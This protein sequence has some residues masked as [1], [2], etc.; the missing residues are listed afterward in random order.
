[1]M[2]AFIGFL[3]TYPLKRTVFVRR[4]FQSWS[5]STRLQSK[6]RRSPAVSLHSALATPKLRVSN[7]PK[8]WYVRQ[9][10]EKL[11]C[12]CDYI[13]SSQTTKHTFSQNNC[14]FFLKILWSFYSYNAIQSQE[15]GQKYIVRRVEQDRDFLSLWLKYFQ[16]LGLSTV[17]LGWYKIE[18]TPLR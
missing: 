14:G 9:R 2:S 4:T 1:M 6:K 11:V 13:R 17:A 8:M 7:P 3:W 12:I 5:F 18:S 10:L 15:P 16:D